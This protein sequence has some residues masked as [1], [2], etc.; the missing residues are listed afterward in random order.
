MSARNLIGAVC[1]VCT[2]M[3]ASATAADQ[4]LSDAAQRGDISTVRSLLQENAEVNGTQGDGMTAL[5]WAAENDDLEMARVLIRAGADLGVGTRVGSITPLFLACT[6]GY[7][8]MAVL[9]LEAGADANS[10]A[11]AGTTALM[12]ASAAGSVEVVEALLGHGADV[13]RKEAARQQTALMYAAALDRSAVVRVLAERGADLDATSKVERIGE[14]LF[15]EDGN[16]MPAISRTGLTRGVGAGSP[17]PNG[18]V[19][20]LG[21]LTALH[22]ASREGH[23]D[24]V[25][26]LVESGARL[27]EVSPMDRS[28]PLVIAIANGHYDLGRYLLD[29]GADPNLVTTAGYSPLHATV[30]TRWSP[31]SW[32]PTSSTAANGIL[33]QESTYL[34]LMKELLLRGADPNARI[35]NTLWFNP[36]HHNSLWIETAGSTAF[37]RAAQASDVDAMK[38][39]VAFGA[40]PTIRSNDGTTTLAVATGVGWAGNFSTNVPDSFMATIEYLVEESG[41]DVNVADAT[42]YTALMGAAWRGD[43]EMVRYLVDQGAGLDVRTELGWSVT[44]MANGPYLRSSVPVK[45]PETV[46]LLRELGAPELIQVDDE[47]ILGIIK[48]KIEVPEQSKKQPNP[49]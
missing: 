8:D 41:I 20:G 26:A 36:P 38:L 39:L 17:P 27:D 43:N 42:G 9:L 10:V 23:M 14:V 11:L 48:R 35:V 30:E 31:V 33:Q 40:D 28:S 2:V 16:P 21:G 34:D 5:H 7:R 29:Q 15:D 37:W 13:D 4:R 19:T 25:R 46:A 47:E 22:Y 24:T 12:Q 44:D 1:F 18:A 6:N 49:R 45:H 3:V 32:T